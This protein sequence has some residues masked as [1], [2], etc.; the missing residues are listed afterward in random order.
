MNGQYL[1]ET[2]YFAKAERGMEFLSTYHKVN[3]EELSAFLLDSFQDDETLVSRITEKE[4]Q[5]ATS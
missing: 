1:P 2:L 5:E 3:K 4:Y